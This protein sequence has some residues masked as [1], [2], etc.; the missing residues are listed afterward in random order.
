MTKTKVGHVADY[1]TPVDKVQDLLSEVKG[2][3]VE[4]PLHY[5]EK[6]DLISK[7]LNLAVNEFTGIPLILCSRLL[8]FLEIIYT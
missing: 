2:Q 1:S 6:V 5:M 3:I 4:M 7:G 8:T